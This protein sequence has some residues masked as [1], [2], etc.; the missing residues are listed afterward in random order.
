M[1]LKEIE[2]YFSKTYDLFVLCETSYLVGSIRSIF[3]A[4]VGMNAKGTIHGRIGIDDGNDRIEIDLFRSDGKHILKT[5]LHGLIN[6]RFSII[7]VRFHF[8]M[9]MGIDVHDAL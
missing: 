5:F 8:E 1:I 2:T 9:A 4:I 6:H 3:I 7:V